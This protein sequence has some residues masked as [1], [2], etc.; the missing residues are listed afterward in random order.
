MA[1]RPGSRLQEELLRLLR[2]RDPRREEQLSE[3]VRPGLVAVG[4]T[5]TGRPVEEIVAAL[6]Q[7]IRTF[8]GTPDRAA[9]AEFAEQI[10]RGENPFE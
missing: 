5:H 3:R 1:R 10:S 6:E 9:L 4:R 7:V 8:G 2:P